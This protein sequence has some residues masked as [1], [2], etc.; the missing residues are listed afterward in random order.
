MEWINRLREEQDDLR[1]AFQWLL[2]I[3]DAERAL[4]IAGSLWRYWWM[5]SLHNEGREWLGD[6]L[7][8]PASQPPALRAKALNGAGVLARGQGDLESAVA[9]LDECLA[10]ERSLDDKNGLA[11]VLNNLGILAHI[12]GEYT[13]AISYYEEGINTWIAA[14][15]SRG[16]AVVLHNLSMIYQEKR[17]FDQAE[18]LLNR[19]LSLFE[20]IGDLRNIAATRMNLGYIMYESGDVRQSE[21][22][23]RKS[24]LPLK[25]LGVRNDIIECLEGFAG[26]A[27][28]L[29]QPR[30]GAQLLG[31]ARAQREVIGIPVARYHQVR[32]QQIVESVKKQLDAQELEEI[33]MQARGMSLDDAIDYALA[34]TE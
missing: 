22:Y 28:V 32:Y 11:N 25:D 21:D 20:K 23:F 12:Q 10:I 3:Q 6:A 1:A 13:R 15:D 14:S 31:V 33:S 16:E 27:A 29:E 26:V 24:L 5:Q 34:G 18:E 2:D 30:R 7:S 19:S 4:R 8:I 9:L 17:E